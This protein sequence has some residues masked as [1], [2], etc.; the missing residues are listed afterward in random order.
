MC[1]IFLNF[2]SLSWSSFSALCCSLFASAFFRRLAAILAI[3]FSVVKCSSLKKFFCWCS[4]SITPITLPSAIIGTVISDIRLASSTT[5][6]SSLE[7]SAIISALPDC[8]TAPTIPVP[9]GIFMASNT[10]LSLVCL[11]P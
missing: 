3:V 11:E 9:K 8:A 7:V 1:R 2:S 4:E 6:L 5:Y 10:F